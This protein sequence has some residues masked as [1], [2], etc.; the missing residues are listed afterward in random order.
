MAS[1]RQHLVAG[2][3][4]VGVVDPLEVVDVDQQHGQRR[5]G[6]Q[7]PAISVSASRCQATALSSPVLAS[8]RAAARSCW[9]SRLR[10]SKITG[11]SATNNS[12]GLSAQAIAT[13]TPTQI[14]VT[15]SIRLSWSQSTS[16]QRACGWAA[17][18]ATATSPC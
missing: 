3:V 13:S 12:S 17:C 8:V 16:A 2:Q 18:A 6:P 14:S 7:H 11:G 15:S 10:C 9:C 5:T 1:A 4:P